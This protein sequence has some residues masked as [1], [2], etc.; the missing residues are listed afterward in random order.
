MFFFFDMRVILPQRAGRPDP[1]PLAEDSVYLLLLPTRRRATPEVE[2]LLQQS[3]GHLAV[4]AEAILSDG[5]RR[6]LAAAEALVAIERHLQT[7]A[8]APD[9]PLS[10]RAQLVLVAMLE[11]DAVVSDRRR[12]VEQIAPRALGPEADA[13]G[14]KQVLAELRAKGMARSK[15]GRGGGFWLT[16]KGHR[17]A[18]WLVETR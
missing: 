16:D 15:T 1:A 18:E 5:S 10:E 14:L 12:P 13:N 17:R 8:G 11:L 4:L 2:R 7:A 6:W 3:S 9:E